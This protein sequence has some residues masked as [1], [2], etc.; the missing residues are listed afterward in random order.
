MPFKYPTPLH[1]ILANSVVSKHLFFE[2]TPCLIWTGSTLVNR[3]GMRYGKMSVRWR[4]GPRKGK[5][6]TIGAHRFVVL[7][8]KRLILTTRM[9]ARHLCNNT[10][11]VNPYHIRG[12]TQSQNVRQCVREGRHKAPRPLGGGRYTEAQLTA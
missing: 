4:S 10:L 5:L 9:P 12:G 1:R 8:V 3:N 2:G 7:Y 6:R 11:C